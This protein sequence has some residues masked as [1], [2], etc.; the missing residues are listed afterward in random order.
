MWCQRVLHV[1]KQENCLLPET[2]CFV[3]CPK[4]FC[5]GQSWFE[6]CSVFAVGDV[7]FPK[8]T[9]ASSMWLQTCQQF[10]GPTQDC[11]LCYCAGKENGFFA[12]LGKECWKW[13]LWGIFVYLWG[14]ISFLHTDDKPQHHS[15]QESESKRISHARVLV[16]CFFEWLPPWQSASSTVPCLLCISP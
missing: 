12:L 7:W 9:L 16:M 11:Y 4:W 14:H 3:P 10:L 8:V 2:H 5:F 1:K 6:G 13:H 15:S